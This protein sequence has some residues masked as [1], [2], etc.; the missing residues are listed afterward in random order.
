MNGAA[1]GAPEP[2]QFRGKGGRRRKGGLV[3][4][5]SG[6]FNWK[7]LIF[8]GKF[9]KGVELGKWAMGMSKL[10]QL[11]LDKGRR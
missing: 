7:I 8:F 4:A 11:G 2:A 6:L 9:I 3:G 5:K 10:P 1:L